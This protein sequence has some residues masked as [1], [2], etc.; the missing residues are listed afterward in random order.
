MSAGRQPTAAL[1]VVG[2][3]T[4][5]AQRL[6]SIY[7]KAGGLRDTDVLA[8][9]RKKTSPLHSQFEWDDTTAAE[10]HRLSQAGALIRRVH[11]KVIPAPESEPIRVR[12]YIANRDLP[13]RS[14]DDVGPGQYTAIADVARKTTYATAVE[15][16]IRRDLARLQV[17][18]S[19]HATF[20]SVLREVVDGD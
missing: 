3:P 16:S 4:D 5:I 6:A 17:K 11:V 12:A 19:S 8:D 14:P 2:V 7:Q 15:E 13:E 9:A 20:F 10:A 18:Y 1:E